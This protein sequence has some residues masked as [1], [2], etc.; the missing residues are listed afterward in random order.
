MPEDRIY[1]P[2]EFRMPRMDQSVP[3][4]QVKPGMFGRLVGTDGRFTGC[5]HKYYGNKK[6]LDLDD[7]TS[8]GG[9]DTYD[10][11]SFFQKVTFQKRNTSTIYHG[12]VVRWDSIDS[13]TDEQVDLIYTDDN[14]STWETPLAIHATGSLIASTD[15][16]SCSV[17]GPYLMIAVEGQ[18][19]KTVYWNGTAL[20]CVD[21][22]PGEF[23]TALGALTESSNAVDAAYYLY[24]QGRYQIAWR[25]YDSARGVYSALSDPI[26]ITL[27][28]MKTTK[29]TGTI[30]FASG[31][32]DA[33][34][35][36]AGDVFTINGRTYEYDDAGSD[37][38]ITAT[39]TATIAAHARALADAINGDASA[40]VTASAQSTSVLIEAVARGSGGN[41]YTLSIAEA[42]VN[43]DDITVSGS[44]LSGGGEATT[45][46]ETNCKII[47]DFPANT[48][49]VT[50]QAYAAFDALF[51][52]IDVFRTIDLGNS[53]TSP[54]AIFYLEQTIAEA[55][56]WETSGTF[57]A[58]QVTVGTVSD[59]AL[60]FLTM[61]D[62]EKD[63]VVA[64]PQSGTI[65]RYAGMT[66]MAQAKSVDGGYDTLHSSMEHASPEY[67]STYNK[68][69][70]DPEDGRPLR[71]ISAG[72]SMFQLCYNAIV[73]IFK[74]KQGAPLQYTRLHAKRGLV[75]KG[76]AHSSG[77]SVFM[78]SGMGMVML[79]ATDGSMGQVSSC[80]R[81]IHDEWKTDLANI[82]SGYDALLNASFFLNPTQEEMLVL[83]HSTQTVSLLEGANFES[84]SSGPDIAGNKND[85]A[86][87]IT[88][89][90]LIVSPDVLQTGT[91]TMW[92]ISSSY[93]VNGTAT[94]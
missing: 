48:A 56:N 27:D 90:G 10:G 38:T 64:P 62:P 18:E 7:V 45:E 3:P 22:G 26:T 29:A 23:D 20:V 12:F 8:M 91:G 25:F 67:F 14:G 66:F 41:A 74:S 69:E 16:M 43:T 46:A 47:L 44:T 13:N 42:G 73:H 59:Q 36:V 83:W 92:D 49:V 32:G 54:G 30:S 52:T 31:G 1:I 11:P 77:N 86:Y 4:N 33:G 39:S 65:G 24:G 80:D 81:I 34:L 71:F 84:V 15:E 87:F 79:N 93:T 88:A 78:V 75:G 28:H 82:Q 68:R 53:I 21:S 40:S 6:M 55:G 72:D 61:Y 58:L 51:D 17:D 63:I 9:I 50:G 19:T 60:P 76:A 89:T 94:G 85:R 35:M 5:L 37:V 70:G 2:Y 57:D